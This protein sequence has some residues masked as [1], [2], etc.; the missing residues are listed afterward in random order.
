MPLAKQNLSSFA[1][2]EISL[3]TLI[4]GGEASL[5]GVRE[6]KNL[7]VNPDF[8]VS[9]RNG[10][11]QEIVI[12][13]QDIEDF[14]FFKG[15]YI[16][17]KANGI[18]AFVIKPTTKIEVPLVFDLDYNQAFSLED[19]GRTINERLRLSDNS[20]LSINSA[21]PNKEFEKFK[22]LDGD[23]YIFF[24]NSLPFKV[25]VEESLF[26]LIPYYSFSGH[27]SHLIGFENVFPFS[28]VTDVINKEDY[29]YFRG[30]DGS[31]YDID[32]E[33]FKPTLAVFDENLD[34]GTGKV[35]LVPGVVSGLETLDIGTYFIKKSDVNMTAF[36]GQP[37][38]AKNTIEKKDLTYRGTYL[39]QVLNVDRRFIEANSF[40]FPVADFAQWP[41]FLR[42]AVNEV[43][44]SIADAPQDTITVT[45]KD[46]DATSD[47]KF[48][49]VNAF[50]VKYKSLFDK[51]YLII[52]ESVYEEEN[53]EF[54]DDE[55]LD[56]RDLYDSL[57]TPTKA[58]IG[59]NCKIIELS[60][61]SQVTATEEQ[62]TV[63]KIGTEDLGRGLAFLR[64]F[65]VH[66][67]IG[68][69]PVDGFSL[70]GRTYLTTRKGKVSV[71]DATNSRI[72]SSP[73]NA[74]SA[75]RRSSFFVAYR[76]F[77]IR[78][79]EFFDVPIDVDRDDYAS[80]YLKRYLGLI[81][82]GREGFTL[83]EFSGN[84]YEL[85]DDDRSNVVVHAV[86]TTG[87]GSNIGQEIRIILFFT[88]K[89]V[90]IWNTSNN[91]FV[92]K[93]GQSFDS[94]VNAKAYRNRLYYRASSGKGVY[95]FKYKEA[96]Q[97][98]DADP[99]ST[100]NFEAFVD[101]KQIEFIQEDRYF[102]LKED[103]SL[104]SGLVYKDEL[105]GLSRWDVGFSI[106]RL[107]NSD[108]VLRF[109]FKDGDHSVICSFKDEPDD[110]GEDFECFMEL[111]PLFV[112]QSGLNFSQV[113]MVKEITILSE[114]NKG[115]EIK[116]GERGWESL[117]PTLADGAS[118]TITYTKQGLSSTL[119][120]YQTVKLRGFSSLFGCLGG[121]VLRYNVEER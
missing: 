42:N 88:D 80:N 47:H 21:F 77:I 58:K 27:A 112:S 3:A 111:N 67:W 78:S 84:V 44:G 28:G 13:N 31:Y 20:E 5:S 25:R 94:N 39:T 95:Y 35:A 15:I 1:Y 71:S 100:S 2:G 29:I 62:L 23:L 38:I 8:T 69:V 54:V 55:Y 120:P 92:K 83:D 72:F 4:R 66:D 64:N 89:G 97:S 12:R 56:I 50:I 37:F 68:D 121:V 118:N 119:K 51:A 49:D 26:Y 33:N 22:E 10:V 91:S 6:L 81:Q 75:L 70:L 63:R 30:A 115:L 106:R 48:F 65:L 96:N 59:A 113:K 40:S 19:G 116:L 103:G 17:K 117:A 101:T 7:R 99:V 86:E 16:V 85:R 105:I 41:L 46:S 90:F 11:K 34:Q 79:G 108:G 98:L 24:K 36:L 110:L 60:A 93:G 109:L 76:E 14:Y 114:R 18:S 45:D 43:Y 74:L 57:S 52:P 32:L 61:K 104:F 107:R 9:P 53:I 87:L 82:E 73:L 102:L